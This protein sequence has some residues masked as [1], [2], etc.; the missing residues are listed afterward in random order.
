MATWAFVYFLIVQKFRLLSSPPRKKPKELGL[1][2]RILYSFL[3]TFFFIL[4]SVL[5]GGAIGIIILYILGLIV[6]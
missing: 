3:L 1:F 4:P 6:K 2:K 5:V